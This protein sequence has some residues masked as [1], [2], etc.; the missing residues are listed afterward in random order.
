MAVV[1]LIL[2]V[3]LAIQFRTNEKS[4]V[5]PSADRWA[6]ITIQ[7]D[8]LR[9]ERDA[10]SEEVISLRAKIEDTASHQQ[11]N[12]IKALND[13]LTKANMVAGLVPTQGPGIIV[14]LNDSAQVL[15]PGDNPNLGLV[16]DEDLLK[17]VNELK[18][19]G[20]E[21]ISINDQRLISSSEIRCAGTTI[22]VNVNRIA[23]PFVISAIG[24]PDM[25]KSS[26]LITG[27]H[28]KYIENFGIQYQI[29]I[30][31]S[32]EIPA[33]KGS[34]KYEYAQPVR[35]DNNT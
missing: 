32:I 25:L 15:Q 35:K 17:V 26:L 34:V 4:P 19:A 16:H 11:S 9:G 29:Q 12:A 23:P 7:L 24:D 18:A 10:L 3:M 30:A 27:G 28:L 13:E 6:E 8:N 22:L 21:A 20:A 31:D 5:N 14:T 2:G 33:Y 1:C